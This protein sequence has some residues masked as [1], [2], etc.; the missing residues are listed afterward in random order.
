MNIAEA[1]YRSLEEIGR[2][3]HLRELVRH[4]TANR[5]FEFGAKSPERALGVAM[6]RRSKGV[7]ISRPVLPFLFYRCAPATYQ[8]IEKLSDDDRD[9]LALEAEIGVAVAAEQASLVGCPTPLG[10]ERFDFDSVNQAPP[11]AGIYAWYAKIDAGIADYRRSLST[12]GTTDLGETNLRQFLL[13]HSHKFDPMP[14]EASAKASFELTWRGTLEPHLATSIERILGGG[15]F[16]D[17]AETER[18][19]AQDIQVPFRREKTRHLLVEV[20]KHATPFL[21]SPIYIGTSDN[22]RRRLTDHT[23]GILKLRDIISAA[24]EKRDEILAS[25]RAGKKTNFAGRATALELSPTELEVY[26]L[27]PRH[28]CGAYDINNEELKSLAACVEWLLNRWHRPL[29][30]RI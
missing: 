15:D 10:I 6:D 27:D 21:T 25:V 17:L 16:E 30:G 18:E 28:M 9:N 4:I 29:A 20:L 8:L 1:A 14:Y 12:D 11:T 3:A 13:R 19:Q 22:L 24:P 5:Y 23:R 2:P 26:T 7:P